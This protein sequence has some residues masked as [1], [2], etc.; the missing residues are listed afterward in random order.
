MMGIVNVDTQLVS[1]ALRH[2]GEDQIHSHRSTSSD[3]SSIT[4]STD[5]EGVK[6][7]IYTST[8]HQYDSAD[9]YD[10]VLNFQPLGIV[11]AYYTLCGIGISSEAK[12]TLHLSGLMH[13]LVG[14][15]GTFPKIGYSLAL[16]RI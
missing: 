16:C 5:S 7:S 15:C 4:E 10:K 9:P 8:V 13:V 1:S 2:T 14:L 11:V 6:V 3:G 12:R